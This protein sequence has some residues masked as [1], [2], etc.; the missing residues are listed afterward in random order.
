MSSPEE[1]AKAIPDLAVQDQKKVGYRYF[2]AN[3]AGHYSL[4]ASFSDDICDTFSRPPINY[5]T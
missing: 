3:R 2:A 1:S 4:L 5:F